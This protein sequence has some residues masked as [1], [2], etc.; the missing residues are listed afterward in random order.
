[1]N[2]WMSGFLNEWINEITHEEEMGRKAAGGKVDGRRIYTGHAQVLTVCPLL[3]DVTL[4][5]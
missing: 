5:T 3:N 4:D 2:E 1:M